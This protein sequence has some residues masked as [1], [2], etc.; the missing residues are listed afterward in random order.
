M[1]NA[2][3][4][5]LLCVAAAAYVAAG[6]D[7][8]AKGP[9]APVP[10]ATD[11]GMEAL[12]W[13]SLARRVESGKIND[14]YMAIQTADQAKEWGDIADVGRLDKVRSEA[15]KKPFTDEQRADAVAIIRGK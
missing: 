1:K 8:S 2:G 11:E 7:N 5:L 15:T 4:I 14:W 3:P 13:D 10:A 6:K 12:W 9:D